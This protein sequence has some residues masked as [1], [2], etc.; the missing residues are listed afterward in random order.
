MAKKYTLNELNTLSREDLMTIVLSMQCQLDQMNENIEKLIEQIRIANQQ[1]FGRKTEKL[2]VMEGQLSLFDEAEALY[3]PDI[4]E[5]QLEEAVPKIKRAKKRSGKREADLSG[6][7]QEEI[8][9]D[10]SRDRLIEVFGEGNYKQMP[11]ETYKRLRYTPASWTV[12]IHTVEVYVGTDGL[13][14]DEFIRGNR[15]KDLLRNSIVTPSLEAAILNGKY[16]N[17]IPLYR[18]EQEFER[19]GVFISRQN[20]ANWTILC[21]ERYF[22][23]LYE[24]LKAEL[25][26]YPVTQADETPVQVV[27]DGR[28]AGSKS[29]MW[30]HRSGEY[31]KERPVVLY[32]Y[33]KTRHH[34]HPEKFYKDYKG[35]LVTDGLNQYHL[36]EKNLKGLINANCWAHARR[37]F[38][39][40]VKAIPDKESAGFSTAY[41]ALVRISAIYKLDESLKE[42]DPETR[43]RERQVNVRPLVEEYFAWVKEVLHTQ[44]PK[45]KTAEG[46]NYSINQEKYLKIF[47][48]DPYVPIDNSASERAIRTFCVGKK[49]WV[50]IDS[51]RGA[52]ASATIYSISETAKLNNLSTY[53]YF[54][55]LLTELPKIV[56]K[57]GNVNA[58]ALE[59]L[60]PWSKELPDT[61]HK[62][63]R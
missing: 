5:P 19:N 14:Q 51:I 30:V 62:P 41:Q 38:S 37:V 50:L 11:D 22:A 16:V 39:D 48:S 45:G 42:L 17:S 61:C 52:Q 12:E 15:P 21:A 8:R 9:H 10:V 60:L 27:N 25:L 28:K 24:R 23:P 26:K 1:R 35:V 58:D 53:N 34:E 63:R 46:L 57:N 40:A 36:I 43:L 31:F 18:I 4:P 49:N 54:N 55:H 7:P 13:H 44:L 33:Q 32:E 56:D 29:Y 47:L 20:M 3:D 59:S 2:N 6:F